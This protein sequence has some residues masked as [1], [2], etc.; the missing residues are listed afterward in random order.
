MTHRTEAMSSFS[1]FLEYVKDARI[2]I[3][4]VVISH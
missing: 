2:Q 3:H 1:L 4:M